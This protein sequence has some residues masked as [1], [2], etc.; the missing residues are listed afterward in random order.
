MFSERWAGLAMPAS[1]GARVS[2]AVVP[3][4]YLGL[5]TGL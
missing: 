2:K 5:A 1:C 4:S 3:I